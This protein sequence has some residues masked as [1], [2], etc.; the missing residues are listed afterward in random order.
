MINF[1]R[2][3][4]SNSYS[5]ISVKQLKHTEMETIMAIILQTIFSYSFLYENCC[6][7]IRI[8][9]LCFFKCPIKICQHWSDNGL[10][11]NRLQAIIWTIDGLFYWRICV[12][13][14]QWVKQRTDCHNQRWLGYDQCSKLLPVRQPEADNFGG[15]P[16]T[17][18]KLFFNFMFMIWDSRQQDW[19]LFWLS[20]EH[21]YD[22]VII[23]QGG[24]RIGKIKIQLS[25]CLIN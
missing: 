24:I 15:G 14:P 1:T 7:F 5:R 8:S 11:P 3:L 17:F 6:I 23:N 4:W 18:L 22:Y 25:L 20:F 2:V 9:L 12:T 16:G 21:W 13:W 10:A 19:Q